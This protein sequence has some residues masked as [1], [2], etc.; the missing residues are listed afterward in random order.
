MI[1]RVTTRLPAKGMVHSSR[2][3]TK[4]LKELLLAPSP[5]MSAVFARVRGGRLDTFNCV[6]LMYDLVRL[7][8]RR[9]RA[10]QTA[11]NIPDEY[12]NALA[13]ALENCSRKAVKAVDI[14]MGLYGLQAFTDGDESRPALV[15]LIDALIA[16][17]ALCGQPLAA[18]EVGMSLYGLKHLSSTTPAVRRLLL[19]ITDKLWQCSELDSQVCA[20]GNLFTWIIVIG[21]QFLVIGC[22]QLLIWLAAYERLRK[23]S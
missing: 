15:R 13:A 8:R 12:V 10:G 11:L 20:T 14:G 3:A 23:R 4:E 17:M 6:T 9:L 18:K 22:R 5:D 7:N 1:K 21:M 2:E 19:A 16:K